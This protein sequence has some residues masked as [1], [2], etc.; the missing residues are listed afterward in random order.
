MYSSPTLQSVL[1]T[2]SHSIADRTTPSMHRTTSLFVLPASGYGLGETTDLM[3]PNLREPLFIRTNFNNVPESN[4]VTAFLNHRSNI[5][6]E[7]K[8]ISLVQST[9]S[10]D[11]AA[12]CLSAYGSSS[13]DAVA[14]SEP[15]NTRSIGAQGTREWQ[16]TRIYQFVYKTRRY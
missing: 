9:I 5:G 4:C 12:R 10:A 7:I 14:F 11:R 1:C 6:F 8:L 15:A 2:L 13:L 16:L 3:L